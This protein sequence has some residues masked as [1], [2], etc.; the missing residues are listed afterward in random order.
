M[1]SWFQSLSDLIGACDEHC[2]RI[3]EVVGIWVAGLATTAAVITSLALARRSRPKFT[4]SAGLRRLFDSTTPSG[5]IEDYPEY[6]AIRVRNVGDH[7]VIIEGIGWHRRALWIFGLPR[8]DGYQ[9]TSGTLSGVEFPHEIASGDSATAYIP[10]ETNDGEDWITYFAKQWVD[11]MPRLSARRLRITAW[12]P[13]GVT[14]EGQIEKDLRKRLI[15]A[16]AVT[17]EGHE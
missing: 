16:A 3:I 1:F 2:L 6:L 4:V 14:V 11:R 9:T 5:N 8:M 7:P 10:I 15:K 17:E 12:T 13:V